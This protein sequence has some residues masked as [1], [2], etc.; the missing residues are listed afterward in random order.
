MHGRVGPGGQNRL[1]WGW[2]LQNFAAPLEESYGE[3]YP[4]AIDSPD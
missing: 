1:L 3:C 4:Q 2:N